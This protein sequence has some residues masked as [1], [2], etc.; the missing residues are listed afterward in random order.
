MA[1][2]D[3]LTLRFA[4]DAFGPVPRGRRRSFILKTD[5]FCKDMDLYTGRPDTV[6]PLPF[7]AMSGYPYG[8]GE[9]YPD[10]EKTREYRRRFNTRRVA[11]R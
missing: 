10:T 6:G 2:G 5:S 9:H 1:H 4:G 7:H 3:E 11:T 8:E